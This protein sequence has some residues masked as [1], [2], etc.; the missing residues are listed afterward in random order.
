MVKPPFYHFT[1]SCGSRK[2]SAQFLLLHFYWRTTACHVIR[3]FVSNWFC[4]LFNQIRLIT[5]NEKHVSHTDMTNSGVHKFSVMCL[6]LNYTWQIM[7]LMVS[8][9]QVVLTRNLEWYVL[10]SHLWKSH[11]SPLQKGRNP[12]EGSNSVSITYI[13]LM[14]KNRI[15]TTIK[16]TQI[17]PGTYYN[18]SSQKL[19]LFTLPEQ[20][21]TSEVAS[22]LEDRSSPVHGFG[23]TRRQHH[24]S[25]F[26]YTI[27]TFK[28][29]VTPKDCKNSTISWDS[30]LW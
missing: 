12:E 4:F 3:V 30:F 13:L 10:S 2:K 26:K 6:R 19:V 7:A 20:F 22:S 18:D 11:H 8:K 29:P 15:N 14:V 17:P 27:C 9:I 23:W 16:Q 25:K 24:I 28:N 1:S 21:C 5:M